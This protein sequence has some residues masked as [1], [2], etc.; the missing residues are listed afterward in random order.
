MEI[1]EAATIKGR[2]GRK[3]P[4]LNDKYDLSN[5]RVVLS[6]AQA[7]VRLVLMQRARDER[8]GR[9]TAALVSGYRGSPIAAL[10]G[11][12][13]RVERLLK[14]N[15]V[16]FRSGLNEDLAATALWGAQQAEL[17]GE[18]RYDG[19]FGIWY[20]KGPGVDRCGDVFRHA[21]H[22]GSSKYGGVLALMGDDHT[23]ESSTSAHQSEFAFVDAM[24]PVLNPAGVQEM[25]DLGQLGLALSRFA[26][27]WVGL[28]CVKDNI[29]STAVVDGSLDRVRIALPADFAM[30]EGGLNIRLHDTAPEKESRLHDHKRR[31]ILE[32][33]RANRIDRII[34]P[35]GP[36]PKIGI[37]T[38]GKSWLDTMQ[39]LSDLGI[40]ELRAAELGLRVY[41]V[42]MTWPLEPKGF[43]EF[44]RG[45]E[46]IIVVEEKRSLVETQIKEQLYDRP[47]RPM[48]IGKRDEANNRDSW[49]FPAKW[50]LEP[51]DIAIAVGERVLRR[52]DDDRIKDR[53]A[54]LKR[55]TGNAPKSA[56]IASRLAYF[57]SGCPHNSSTIVPEGSRAYAGIGCHY[58]AQWMDRRTEGFT[59]MGGEGANW[60]GEAPFS[61]RKHIFQ[62]LGDGTYAHSG[63]LS[64]RAAVSAGTTITFKILYNDAVA[65]TGGQ[66]L[67]KGLTVSAIARQMLAEGVKRVVLVS[68]D[69]GKHEADASIPREVAIYHRRELQGLQTE[70]AAT[71]GVTILIYEQTCAAEKRRR[72][73]RGLFPDPPKRAF[74]NAA[75]CE[76]CG[77]CGRKSNCVSIVPLETDLGRKRAIDQSSCNKD[78]SCVEG[79]CP[80]FVTVHGGRVRK[81]KGVAGDSDGA[82]LIASLVEPKLPSVE[83]PYSLLVTGVGGTG[84]V[85]VAA[86]LGEAAY[87]D[88]LGFGSI[89]MTGLAQKG[90]AVACHIRFAKD[91]A[92]I[93]AI[94]AGISGADAI[95]GGDLVVTASQK[96]LETVA[97]GK[98]AI[99]CNTYE[100]I[101]G[102]FTR[103][104]DF[105]IP[106]LRL[107]RT[108]EERAGKAATHFIDAHVASERLF[109]DSI[110]TNMIMLGYGFE[111]GLVPVT[112]ASIEE[113]IRLNAAA[114]QMNL[115]AFRF[116]RLAAARPDEFAALIAK[117]DEGGAELP[118]DLDSV[119][120]RRKAYL[121]LYQDAALADRFEKK[122]REVAAVE[123]EKSPGRSG[124][125]LAAAESYCKLLAYKDEYEVGRLYASGEFAKSIAGQFEGDVKLEFHL[126]PPL[127]ARRDKLTG[128]PRKMRFG[129][130]MMWAFKLLARMKGLRGTPYDV[131]GYT[132]ERR[133]ERQLIA[134]YEKTLSELG[135]FLSPGNHAIALEIAR[136]PL[137]MKGF[138]HVK[139]ASVKAAKERQLALFASFSAADGVKPSAAAE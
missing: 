43:A 139:L 44:A 113:A 136:L 11:Q 92:S 89:D 30:P 57:C 54:R 112:A 68:D 135:R 16:L 15:N 40:N 138:G 74:I 121:T 123:K 114:V 55:L 69:P 23:C 31:A 26:G 8:E 102:E 52:K 13:L 17:T 110:G 101:T 42:G 88:G 75:V 134:D 137:S 25:L 120:A 32:F 67:E 91:P 73:K 116:G 65:M 129:A 119:I 28:K 48:V 83:A 81:P 18:G 77:D 118:G 56:D 72:R 106:G 93:H 49:L 71:E 84:V 35:G 124:L 70:L 36:A 14:D 37:V 6:G 27:V 64:V 1:Q 87:L 62:N 22:A 5:A 133:L 2:A 104:P 130:W 7:I 79:F 53:I 50:A 45:L 51:I 80:S 115:A 95:I 108:I 132:A 109:G 47:D 21:N 99:V 97:E 107:R 76:G 12:F 128:E 82:A 60:I 100:Q 78:F 126:A 41:K 38:M 125:A 117:K 10:E 20:G 105:S 33:A 131:F 39:A 63:S 29:E 98:T 122:V 127:L 90:G 61:K 111:L 24:M 3:K 66:T 94:R 46:L 103:K 58:M 59:Q 9:H 19:V 85:T 96:S 34:Y 86:I 4:S